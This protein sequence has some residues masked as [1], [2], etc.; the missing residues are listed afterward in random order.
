M[1]MSP[2]GMARFMCEVREW[3]SLRQTTRIWNNLFIILN[4]S[5]II[6]LTLS[7]AGGSFGVLTLNLMTLM[8]ALSLSHVS[9]GVDPDGPEG[10]NPGEEDIEMGWITCLL[11]YHAIMAALV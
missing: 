3:V 8:F 1:K 6:F 11:K 7:A 9:V 10:Q 2:G 5:L 4:N